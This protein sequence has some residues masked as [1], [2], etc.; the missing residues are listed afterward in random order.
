M[1]TI[2]IKR[3]S[4]KAIAVRAPRTTMELS[5]M[6]NNTCTYRFLTD[7][8]SFVTRLT[9]CPVIALSKKAMGRRST[10]PYTCSRKRRTERMATPASRV[11]CK[12]RSQVAPHPITVY[13]S[14]AQKRANRFQRGGDHQKENA[15][16]DVAFFIAGCV[17]QQMHCLFFL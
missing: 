14:L 16:P 15:Q 8:V 11:S 9:S 17:Q 2:S 6:T 7:S 5:S 3:H 13:E 4:S 10:C 1:S 12:Q